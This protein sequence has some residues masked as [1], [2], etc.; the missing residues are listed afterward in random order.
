MKRKLI[1]SALCFVA[2]GC[3]TFASYKTFCQNKNV[4]EVMLVENIEALTQDESGY[5]GNYT[6][7]SGYCPAPCRYKKW[8]SCKSGEKEECYP[9]DC[10]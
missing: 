9:S 3:I 4:V 5:K 2:T 10:C 6:K 7:S 1:F 8:V